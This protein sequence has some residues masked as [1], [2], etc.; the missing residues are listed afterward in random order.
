MSKSSVLDVIKSKSVV[1][2]T[3]ICLITGG[4]LA[5]TYNLTRERI[6][7]AE[8]AEINQALSE[9]FPSA[10]FVEENDYYMALENGEL[11]GYAMIV[12]GRGFGGKIK[13]A[14]GIRLDG[15]IQ[16]VR[17]IS[18]SE[19]PGL[20]SK[21]AGDEFLAQFEGKTLEELKLKKEGGEIDAVT[22]AT[23]SSRAVVDIVRE[24]LQKMMGRLAEAQE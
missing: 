8:Q 10:E 7:E 12:E 17:V 24:E 15:T 4:M 5:V 11:I 22:G 9:I 2:L 13:A 19:T 20:G 16:R 21:V 3:L 14:I 23:I 18:H 1:V 6:A